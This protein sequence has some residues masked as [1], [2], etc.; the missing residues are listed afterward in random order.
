MTWVSVGN[1]LNRFKVL[2]PPEEFV[3]D[4]VAE[5]VRK[6]LNVSA[7]GGHNLE[8]ELRGGILYIKTKNPALKNQIF[9]SKRQILEELGKRLGDRIKEIRF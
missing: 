2:K 9:M 6:A 7:L 4:E 1:Y 8:A 5:A 3:R